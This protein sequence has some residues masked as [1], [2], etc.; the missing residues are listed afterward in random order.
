[1]HIASDQ[2]IVVERPMYFTIGSWTGG[3]DAVAV[4]DSALSTTLNFA[5]GYVGSTFAEYYTILN[6]SAS[7]ATVTLTYY[8]KIGGPV[9]KTVI[10]AANSRFTETVAADLPAGSENSVKITSNVPLLAERPMYFAY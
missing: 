4:P 5:E 6:S 2:P 8:L 1:V 9:S 7:P 10:V 3:H